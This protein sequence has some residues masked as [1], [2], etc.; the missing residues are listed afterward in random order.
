MT[1]DEMKEKLERVLS[2]KRYIHSINVMRTAMELADT[3]K[4]DREKAAVAGLLHDCARDVRGDELLALCSQYDIEV[5]EL[6]R[7]QPELLHGPLGSRMAVTEFDV[8][9]TAVLS[10]IGSHTLGKAGM[11]TLEKIILLADHIEPNRNFPGVQEVR[12]LAC[13]DLNKAL[14]IALDGTIQ[15][16]I[17]KGALVH[18]QTVQARNSILMEETRL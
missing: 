12:E 8:H 15:H 3:Y 6:M 5:N 14:L 17:A 2:P 9:D 4:E 18:P 10:A 13:R 11:S 7:R 16:V 1:L